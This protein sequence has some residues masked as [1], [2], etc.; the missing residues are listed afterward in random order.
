MS[1]FVREQR[2]PA[3]V[4][5][6]FAIAL[7][8]ML[9]M[10]GVALD[11]G[12]LYVQRRTAQNAADAAA[13][14][15]ARAMQQ[16]TSSPS[17]SIPSEI[18]KYVVANNF[19]VTPNVSAYFVDV[20]GS[21]MAGGDIALPAHCQGLISSTS[22]WANVAGVHVDVTMGPYD[23]Y[24]VGLV[25]LRQL[26]ASGGAT[27]QVWDYAINANDIAPWAVCGHSAPYDTY[28]D[29]TDVLNPNNTI[30]QSAINAHTQIILESAKMDA[31]ASSWLPGPPACPDNNGSSWKG[32]I[33][34]GSGIIIL[35]DNANTVSGNGSID[36]PC[37]ATGQ[38]SANCYLFVPV[39]DAHN[40]PGEA[41]IVTFACM[42]IT[43]GGSGDDK[44]WGTL[45]PISACPTYPYQ[46]VWTWGSGST[47]TIVALTN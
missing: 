16:A 41:H 8:A 14:A 19:G 24:L 15:G 13:L 42:Q 11:G 23:T 47:N 30:M 28:G 43:Q 37:T 4:I 1:W 6:L 12:T 45:D 34:P 17:A 32:K 7:I 46:P 10:L 25:G 39:T 18:C 5:V 3:Q 36:D 2:Q 22:V 20:N 31:G 29:L 9:A 38:T 40:T 21:K 27:A 26:S 33:D 35:P 44:W